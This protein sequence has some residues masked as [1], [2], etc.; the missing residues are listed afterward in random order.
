MIHQS[1]QQSQSEQQGPEEQ[2]RLAEQQRLAERFAPV[3]VMWPEI[4]SSAHAGTQTRD[5]YTRQ[6]SRSASRVTSGA[7]IVR[8]FYPRGVRVIMDHAQPWEP[9]PPLPLVPVGFTLAYRDYARFFFWPFAGIVAF[10]LLVVGLAQGLAGFPRWGI[11]I[12]A[13]AIVGALYLL[14]LR[15]PILVPVDY[16]HHLNHVVLGLGALV[17]WA[18]AFGPGGLWYVAPV[19]MIPSALAVLT[20]IAIGI[21]KGLAELSLRLLHVGRNLGLMLLNRQRRRWPSRKRLKSKLFHG[22]REPHEYSNASELFFRDPKDGKPMH[23]T[24][25]TAYWAAYSRIRAR[26]E[27]PLTFYARVMEPDTDGS[28]VIQYWFCYYYDDWANEHECDWE[29]VLV[30]LRDGKPIT[31][32]CS[33]HETGEYRD[34][35]HVETRGD[36]PVLYVSA[37]SHAIYFE[38]GAYLTERAVAGLRVTS[39]DAEVFGR[40]VFEFIDFTPTAQDKSF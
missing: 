36:R 38:P 26:G 29:T 4:P 18:A 35:A 17:I 23:R 1:E 33:Q 10:A 31:A 20:S 25:R 15:S 14:S 40:D 6:Q 22:V 19:V 13:L 39:L 30:V 16:W 11:E 3:L 2:H 21:V 37:G 7:H 8:D 24:D 32:A 27:Y 28:V 34:W 12:G 5:M 9:K